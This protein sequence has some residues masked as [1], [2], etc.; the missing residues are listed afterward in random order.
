MSAVLAS[1]SEFTKER[2]ER[3]QWEGGAARCSAER[4]RE[5]IQR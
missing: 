2:W 4:G 5:I 3:W 1:D